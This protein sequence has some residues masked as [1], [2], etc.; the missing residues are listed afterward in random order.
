MP[1][2]GAGNTVERHRRLME[3]GREN[4]SLARLAEAHWD[5]IAILAEAGR[6]PGSSVVYGVWAS[7]KPG[8]YLTLDSTDG[9]KGE[10]FELHGSKMFCTGASI[11]DR[12][13]VTVSQPHS[14]LVEIDLRANC[15]S[16]VYDSSD[17]KTPAFAGTNTA[18]V[19]FKNARVSSD[20]LI[21]EPQWYLQRPG[22]WHGALGP[23]ACWAGGAQG[24]LDYAISQTRHDPH[25]LAHLGAMHASIWALAAYLDVAGHEIDSMRDDYE[26]AHRRAL[27]VRHLIEQACT[28]VLRRLP[29]AYGP[30][31]LAMNEEVLRRYLEL[32][33]Y[34]RQSHAERDLESL[35]AEIQRSAGQQIAE[36][37]AET[38]GPQ[39]G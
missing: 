38:P 8:Q 1:L 11:V 22:F 33:L 31:P 12:A 26:L 37:R 5:A 18:T 10:R 29:R 32:D 14:R 34:L 2:P 13:L 16:I 23:A 15:D 6:E 17:W 20:D 28:E 4:L 9:Q 35:G 19:T 3:V 36:G 24:L 7:E 39:C 25:T 30:H 21:G 27:T